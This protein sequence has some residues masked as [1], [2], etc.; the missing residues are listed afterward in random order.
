MKTSHKIYLRGVDLKVVSEK[1]NNG[2][3]GTVTLNDFMVSNQLE[4][5]QT[6]KNHKVFTVTDEIDNFF[7]VNRVVKDL[8]G[9]YKIIPFTKGKG[10]HTCLM[11][12]MPIVGVYP[13]GIPIVRETIGEKKYYQCVDLFD[14][15]NCMYNALKRRRRDPLVKQWYADSEAYTLELFKAHHPGKVLSPARDRRLLRRNNGVMTDTEYHTDAYS[16]A[17]LRDE[18]VL[19]PVAQ[20]KTMKKPV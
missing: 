14:T 10:A 13:I 11:C 6:F 17:E 7:I 3:Y 4:K 15:F 18:Y 5:I 16:L 9:N 2:E 12:S 19:I 20:I 8:S 1:Y